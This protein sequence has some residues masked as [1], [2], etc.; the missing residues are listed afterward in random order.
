MIRAGEEITYNESGEEV[1]YTVERAQSFA[2]WSSQ[3]ANLSRN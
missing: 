1:G 3:D 2:F